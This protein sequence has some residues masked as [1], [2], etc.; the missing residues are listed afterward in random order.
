MFKVVS[1]SVQIS[2]KKYGKIENEIDLETYILSQDDYDL[3]ETKEF[4]TKEEAIDYSATKFSLGS[5]L[6]RGAVPYVEI[7]YILLIEVDEYGTEVLQD[8]FYNWDEV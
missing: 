2:L 6:I 8:I 7:D 5:K 3:G 1:S 4:E